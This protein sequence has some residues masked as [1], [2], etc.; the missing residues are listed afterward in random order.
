M[1]ETG[2]D[3]TDT[4]VTFTLLASL[5]GF[6]GTV[7]VTYDETVGATTTQK[8]AQLTFD[9]I[10]DPTLTVLVPND[11]VDNGPETV[12]LALVSTTTPETVVDPT[13]ATAD[14]TEDDIAAGIGASIAVS[15]VTTFGNASFVVENT[16]DPGITI[17]DISFDIGTAT[18]ST[19]LDLSGTGEFLGAVWDPTAEA[20][21]AGGQG[22]I[23]NPTVGNV[24]GMI[25]PGTGI[26]APVGTEITTYPFSEQLPGSNGGAPGG[27]RNMDLAFKRFRSGRDLPVRHRCRPAVDPGRIGHW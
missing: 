13:A 10:T 22:L 23:I 15:G 9:G 21:D 11:D 25:D 26:A 27:Y 8:T 17:T 3:G 4:P 1:T 2:D 5:P 18:L 14:V 7:D 19:G 24:A 6:I 12:S 20:G 16:S